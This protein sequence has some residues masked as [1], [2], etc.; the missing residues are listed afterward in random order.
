MLQTTRAA[1]GILWPRCDVCMSHLLPS[2]F[3]QIENSSAF[4]SDWVGEQ[5]AVA[6]SVILGRGQGVDKKM[7][8]VLEAISCVSIS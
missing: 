5:T 3:C 1:F 4:W 7:V 8:G 2:F 6:F